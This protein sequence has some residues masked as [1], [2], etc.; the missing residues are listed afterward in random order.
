MKPCGTSIIFVDDGNRVLLFLRDDLPGVA[1]PGLWDLPGGHPEEG[2]TP[3]ECIVR[4]LREELGIGLDRFALFERA[5]FPDRTEYTFWKR[6]NLDTQR[7]VLT[8]GQ[9]MRWFT[10]DEVRRT[11][12]AFGFNAT[13]ERFF[14]RMTGS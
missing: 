14:G 13:V 5:E 3:E 9:G 10:R 4:E 1:C 12:L 7:L 8:E 2:E 11:P 6:E